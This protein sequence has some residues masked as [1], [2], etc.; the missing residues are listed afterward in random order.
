MSIAF[1]HAADESTQTGTADD[2]VLVVEGHELEAILRPDR[3]RKVYIESMEDALGLEPYWRKIYDLC[4]VQKRISVRSHDPEVRRYFQE[5]V[6]A[7]NMRRENEQR[8]AQFLMAMNAELRELYDQIAEEKAF[9]RQEIEN[10]SQQLQGRLP[11]PSGSD[12][13]EDL[14]PAAPVVRPSDSETDVTLCPPLEE[15]PDLTPSHDD[16]A[17]DQPSSGSSYPISSMEENRNPH[18]DSSAL[19]P[20]AIGIGPALAYE[21]ILVPNGEKMEEATEYPHVDR[22][23]LPEAVVVREEPS[24]TSIEI[25]V[26]AADPEIEAGSSDWRSTGVGRDEEPTADE[27][28]A[29]SEGRRLGVALPKET[30]NGRMEEE[31]FTLAQGAMSSRFKSNP[32]KWQREFDFEQ[33]DTIPQDITTPGTST[34]IEADSRVTTPDDPLMGH[35]DLTPS[36]SE[37][38]VPADF[39]DAMEPLPSRLQQKQERTPPQPTVGAH[40]PSLEPS[41]ITRE[42]LA[43]TSN[44]RKSAGPLTG[45]AALG[46]LAL[47]RR[48]QP[49]EEQHRSWPNSIGKFFRRIRRAV[50]L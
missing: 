24:M 35:S 5:K 10:L 38:R 1:E 21:Q 29:L 23:L 28:R 2:A 46:A 20:Y 12:E 26:R 22:T 14:L 9:L 25:A 37:D 48:L 3:H 42:G 13:W 31:L 16:I 36:E 40:A 32:A 15:L 33:Q 8:V 49:S 47:M 41:P 39:Y 19:Q 45:T 11:T 27:D 44:R 6:A 30:S 50:A 17:V 43:I 4:V 34:A 7:E 18:I